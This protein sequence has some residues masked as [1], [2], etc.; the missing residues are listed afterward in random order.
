MNVPVRR[1]FYENIKDR[2]AVASHFWSASHRTDNPMLGPIRESSTE[3]TRPIERK[4]DLPD[5]VIL[6]ALE[7]SMTPHHGSRGSRTRRLEFQFQL[8]GPSVCVRWGSSYRVLASV[9]ASET[10]LELWMSID[11]LNLV[12]GVD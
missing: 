8:I 11:Q 1:D 6:C 7:D 2:D 3:R 9:A 5:L 10:S 4:A 12:H